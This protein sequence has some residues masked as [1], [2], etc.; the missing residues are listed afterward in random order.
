MYFYE[1]IERTVCTLTHTY[2]HTYIHTYMYIHK[3]IY[4]YIHTYIHTF[5]T[6]YYQTI[7]GVDL[8]DR[9]SAAIACA[10]V[11][12]DIEPGVAGD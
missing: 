8:L 1:L 9:R 4:S 10:M 3:Y 2:I 5:N 6:M 7:P 12:A 11:Q